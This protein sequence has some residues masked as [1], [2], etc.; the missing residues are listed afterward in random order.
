MNTRQ[1]GQLHILFVHDG[2]EHIAICPEIAM[3]KFGDD[4]E[5]LR[6]ET[7]KAARAYT[8]A[9]IENNLPHEL[10][11]R[12]EELP[13]KYQLLYEAF[14]QNF[15]QQGD[16]KLQKKLPKKLQHAIDSGNVLLT[17]AAVVPA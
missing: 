3:V 1:Q 11:N 5:T 13:E 6:E 9:I 15:K 14:M 10:L 4:F 2:K 17:S 12:T 16:Q 7:V 8:E